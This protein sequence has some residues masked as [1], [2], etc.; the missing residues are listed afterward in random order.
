MPSDAHLTSPQFNPQAAP[1]TVPGATSKHGSIGAEDHDL[2]AE[3][4]VDPDPMVDTSADR[5]KFDLYF[6]LERGEYGDVI[7]FEG[8]H[9]QEFADYQSRVG[10]TNK[11][12]SFAQS[13]AGTD[14]ASEGTWDYNESHPDTQHP[15]S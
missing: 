1:W 12:A 14:Y 9:P 4:Y 15:E 2:Y 13:I 11:T 8:M 6:G 3:D 10:S 5:E 7:D